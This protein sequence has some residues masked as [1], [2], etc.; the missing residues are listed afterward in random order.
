MAKTVHSQCKGPG[1]I[2]SQAT[3]SH[4]PQLNIPCATT[5]DQVQANK[6]I[7]IYIYF[8][9]FFKEKKWKMG[10]EEARV[11]SHPEEVIKVKDD[12]GY[13][14]AKEVE[15]GK[16]SIWLSHIQLFATPWMVAHQNPLTMEFS[17]QEY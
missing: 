8:F 10:S 1:S 2:P 13:T 9:L 6:Y 11:R 7:Y 14:R 12:A 15:I 5:I 16:R 4:I 3:R 17:Q